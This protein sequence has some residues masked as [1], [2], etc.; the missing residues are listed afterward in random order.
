MDIAL[1]SRACVSRI[2]FGILQVNSPSPTIGVSFLLS[3]PLLIGLLVARG[4][5]IANSEDDASEA[6]WKSRELLPI[7]INEGTGIASPMRFDRPSTFFWDCR[8]GV[9]SDLHDLY[10]INSRRRVVWFRQVY[11]IEIENVIVA[12]STNGC[13]MW[14]VY[15]SAMFT[16]HMGRCWKSASLGLRNPLTLG[17]LRVL[18][19]NE[20]STPLE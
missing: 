8:E 5:I 11:Q 10:H 7:W 16:S 9:L 4:L 3:N 13:G 20:P 2:L 6:G 12:G 18:V 14:A 19:G 15:S 17:R 1:A